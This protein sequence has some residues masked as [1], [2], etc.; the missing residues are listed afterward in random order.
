MELYRKVSDPEDGRELRSLLRKE[1]R[2]SATLLRRLKAACAISV[3]GSGVFTNYRVRSGDE[4]LV[5]ISE[6]PADYPAEY[7]PL[8]ILYEDEYLLAA[9]KPS[10]M[11]IHPSHSR[12]TGTLANYVLGYT[13]SH[14]GEPPH[15]VNRLDRDTGG[16]VL[17]SKGGYIKT[18]MNDAIVA[19]E[20]L[21]VV[22]GVPE[23]SSGAIEL[24]IRRKSE[25]DML[26]I[27]AP[28]GA[29]ARTDYE[30]LASRDGLSLLR[31]CL[32][33]GRTHQIRVHCHAMG[34]PI[35]GDRLYFTPQSAA[36][37]EC[38]SADSQLLHACRLVFIHPVSGAE[39]ELISTP[40]WK[41]HFS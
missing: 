25:L 27:V 26:R 7:G 18:L 17:F 37:S 29:A 24:P 30:T 40:F 12:F 39:T 41:N 3:N 28:D 38:F 21:A 22:C 9:D 13:S 14:G 6:P 4:I 32:H 16:I 33:T 19:K 23:P 35:L 1:M 31:L 34:W 8:D 36:A 15:A 11:L 20:Y 2:L 5:H 10:G